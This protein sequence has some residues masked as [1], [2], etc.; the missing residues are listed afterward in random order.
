MGDPGILSFLK[1]GVQF[2][3]RL[4]GGLIPGGRIATAA[5]TGITRTVTGITRRVGGAIVQ[6]P[7]LSAAC[8]AGVI[9]AAA[10]SGAEAM[11]ALPGAVAKGFHMIKKGPHAGRMARNRRMRVTNPRALRRALRRTYGFERL[12][13]KVIR[14]HHPRKRVAFGGFRPRKKKKAA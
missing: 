12:A 8:A 9:G 3:G 14:L 2:G 1:K 13:M 4:F 6:H 10:G 5:T 11:R 7:V